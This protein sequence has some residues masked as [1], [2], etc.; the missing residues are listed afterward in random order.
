MINHLFMDERRVTNLKTL[1]KSFARLN[2]RGENIEREAWAADFAK[3]K[4]KSSIILLH[5]SPGTGKTYTAGECMHHIKPALHIN[6]TLHRMHSCLHKTSADDIDLERYRHVSRRGSKGL[7]GPLQDSKEL[8][9]S[10]TH[11]ESR[12]L[13]RA[14]V[15]SR[16]KAQQR[17]SWSVTIPPGKSITERCKLIES[18]QGF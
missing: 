11:R 1:S 12:R 4:G 13:S 9:L 14:S 16:P 2:I 17:V 18:S 3:G 7:D 8:G 15:Y 10:F 6:L 5:G